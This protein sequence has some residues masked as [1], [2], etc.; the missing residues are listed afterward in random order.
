MS[1]AKIEKID[2]VELIDVI[3]LS[4]SELRIVVITNNYDRYRNG[5]RRIN[6]KRP[7]TVHYY[8]VDKGEYYLC[9]NETDSGTIYLASNKIT[10]DYKYKYINIYLK[11]YSK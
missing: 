11:I 9:S 5:I 3:K 7:L 1:K 10:I 6:W 4:G 8:L 2:G